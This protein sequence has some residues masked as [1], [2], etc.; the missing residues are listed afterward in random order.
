[1]Y[2]PSAPILN[3]L[4]KIHH[5]NEPNIPIRPVINYTTAPAYKLTQHLAKV[6][7]NKVKL[8]DTYN[9]RNTQHL[10]QLTENI[11]L[12][13]NSCLLSFDITNLYTSIPITDTLD[14]MKQKLKREE[15]TQFVH[16]LTNLVQTTTTQNYF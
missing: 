2:E 9:I 11:G 15:S 16:Q 4:P 1:M 12:T 5:P 13:P 14:I 8:N 3:A 7:K 10:I 6:I